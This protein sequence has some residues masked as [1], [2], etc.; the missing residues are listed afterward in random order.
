MRA[1]E[2]IPG[3]PWP[4]DMV[5]TIETVSGPLTYLLF[6]RTAWQLDIDT[7]PALESEPNVGASDRPSDRDVDAARAQWLVEW[8]RAWTQF[9]SRQRAIMTP[10]AEIQHLLDTLT[11]EELQEALS[12]QPSDY[13]DAGI[14]QKAYS[15]WRRLLQPP[16]DDSPENLVLP[17]LIPA[18]ESG[19]RTI[20]QLPYRGYF[21][22]R[23]NREHLVV[24]AATRRDPTL[25]DRAL[26]S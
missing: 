26:R 18:W 3:D 11:D 23:I 24:S 13:W 12:P 4:H 20:I 1:L 14:D 21:A 17:A 5:L 19:L 6:V 16:I 8:N 9:E 10:D 25:F 7:V 22:E 15:A 2:P